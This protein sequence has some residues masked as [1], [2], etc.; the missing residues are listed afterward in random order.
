M[1][2]H[3]SAV[4]LAYNPFAMLL[5]VQIG[6]FFFSII[7]KGTFFY[8]M[9]VLFAVYIRTFI[10]NG[11]GTEVSVNEPMTVLLPMRIRAIY[12]YLAIIISYDPLAVHIG[13]LLHIA[14]RSVLDPLAVPLALL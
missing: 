1:L 4:G 14:V 13:A 12:Y 9:T 6:A 11:G 3:H 2:H 10:I 5:A 8:P 7:S